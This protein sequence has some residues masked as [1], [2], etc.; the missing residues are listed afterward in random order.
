[1]TIVGNRVAPWFVDRYLARTNI[2]AQ[3]TGETIPADRPDNLWQP[4][5]GD[6]GAHGM[7]DE[8]AKGR[9][10]QYELNHHRRAFAA[11][12]GAALRPARS[13]PGEPCSVARMRDQPFLDA[14]NER[15]VVFDG[16]FGTF[17]QGL[18]LTADDFGGPELE[19]CNEMV[20][21]R[22]PDV[23]AAMHDD[24]FA[25]GVD[26]VGAHRARGVHHEHHGRGPLGS[27]DGALRARGGQDQRRQRDR[28]QQGGQV[29]APARALGDHVGQQRGVGER[30]RLAPAAALHGFL[31]LDLVLPEVGRGG[32]GFET[33]QLFVQAG[34][35][36]DSSADP[37]RAC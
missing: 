31:R 11:G 24:F 33:G 32:A 9:S 10:A 8:R 12:A 2:K 30:R 28:Q 22:R 13:A 19:G 21:L 37:Q 7:F 23:I 34:G 4:P 20:C 15:I 25:V 5:P 14:V 17:I 1:M 36:K 6:P 35:F 29:A 18:D 16:A 26:V 3:Q 27:G